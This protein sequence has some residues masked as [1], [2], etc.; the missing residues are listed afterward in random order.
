MEGGGS[1]LW[2]KDADHTVLTFKSDASGHL[3]WGVAIGD[4]LHFSTWTEEEASDPDMVLKEMVPLLYIAETRGEQLAGQI[5]R[6][7]VDNSGA[8]FNALTGKGEGQVRVLMQRLTEMQG[9]HNFD[10]L[11]THVDREK[12][13]LSDMLTRFLQAAQLEGELPKGWELCGESLRASRW[14]LTPSS[15]Q[16]WM[17]KLRAT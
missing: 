14:R 13:K 6:M 8:V 16:V 3:G 12:N 7:G 2:L 5:V 4:E 17:M 11:G 10:M 1:R 9:K 15:R